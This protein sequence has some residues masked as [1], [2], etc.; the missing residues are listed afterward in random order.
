[1]PEDKQDSTVDPN[2]KSPTG[3]PFPN[4]PTPP[5]VPATEP[6]K[7]KVTD[8]PLDDTAAKLAEYKRTHGHAGHS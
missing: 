2:P 1:M 8:E 3:Y 4:P 6:R 5:I 7:V